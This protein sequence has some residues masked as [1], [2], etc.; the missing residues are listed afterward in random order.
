MTRP[1]KKEHER[2]PIRFLD[3]LLVY[4]SLDEGEKP[5]FR[6]CREG[7]DIALEVTEYHSQSAVGASGRPRVAIKRCGGGSS[8]HSFTVNGRANRV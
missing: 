2:R 8:R 4:T 5:D 6:I 3:G 7:G 1:S